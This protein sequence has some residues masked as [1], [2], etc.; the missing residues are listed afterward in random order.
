[1]PGSLHVF[2]GPMASGKTTNVIDSLVKYTLIA[3]KKVLFINHLRD[4]RK[5]SDKED[6]EQTSKDDDAKDVSIIDANSSDICVTPIVTETIK[7]STHCKVRDARGYHMIDFI[8]L[9]KLS[10]LD[11][12]QL[13]QYT[14]IGIDEAQFYPDLFDAVSYFVRVMH[15]TVYVSGLDG[16]SSMKK[17]GQVSD[18]SCIAETYI[19]LSAVCGDCVNETG[20]FRDAAFT[21]YVGSAKKDSQ[22]LVGGLEVYAP[23]CRDHHGDDIIS[24]DQI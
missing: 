2:V 13:A 11:L 8:S 12:E 6:T 15:K 7:Y 23:R 24:T 16:D 1:M 10:D 21:K 9:N 22:L 20:Q 5:P 17:F 19:K 18:L 4:N 3:K 14:V